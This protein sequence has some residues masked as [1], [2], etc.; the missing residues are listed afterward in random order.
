MT[1]RSW[2][3]IHVELFGELVH[4]DLEDGGAGGFAGG[5]HE[6]GDAE[7]HVDELVGDG[8][9]LAGVERLG[10]A[11]GVLDEVFDDGGVHDDVVLDGEELAVGGGAE[12][13]L[14]DGGGAGADGAEHL[15]AVEDELDGLADD[16]GGHG[17]RAGRATTM[18]PLEPKP[19]PV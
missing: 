12:L 17:G 14:V 4:G 8:V 2:S 1:R 11:G 9:G 10:G 16:L 19:P 15:L 7:V 5:A 18:E 13:D 3:G 6:G